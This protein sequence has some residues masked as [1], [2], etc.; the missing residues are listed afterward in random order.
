MLKLL[1]VG[2]TVGAVAAA[3]LVPLAPAG[4]DSTSVSDAEGDLPDIL[5]LTLDNQQSQVVFKQKFAS[6]DDVMVE[7]LYIKWGESTHYRVNTGNYDED[8]ALETRLWLS[9]SS[10]DVEK[11]CDVTVSRNADTDVSIHK[12]PRSC[13]PKAE[14]KI[15]GRGVATQGM[16]SIDETKNTAKVARG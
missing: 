9:K 8:V 5:K 13:L 2:I 14:N 7:S 4:A 6:L 3:L 11:T 16:W 15:F 10:G 12:V 1:R